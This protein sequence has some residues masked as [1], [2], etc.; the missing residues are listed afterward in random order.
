M[1]EI[2][3]G[4]SGVEHLG[5]VGDGIYNPSRWVRRSY[6]AKLYTYE[7]SKYLSITPWGDEYGIYTVTTGLLFQGYVD[8]YVK[9]N[10]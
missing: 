3:Q 4:R 6:N 9:Q 7:N 10:Q 1:R 5:H 8:L 2:L